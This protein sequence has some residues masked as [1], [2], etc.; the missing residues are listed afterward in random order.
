MALHRARKQWSLTE[1]ETITSFECW[2]QI[3]LY[4]LKSD[5]LFKDFLKP[6][7]TWQKKTK[8]NANR[9][10][11]DTAGGLT[12]AEKAENLELMLEQLANY[13]TIISRK[14]I[15]DNSTSMGQIWQAIRV[16]FGFQASGAHFLD[17]S[18]IIL[19]P[20]E[21]P[22]TLYQRLLAFVED[23]LLKKDGDI[24]HEGEAVKEDEELTPSL[25]NYVVLH[26]L[27]LVHPELP[28]SEDKICH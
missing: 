19:E 20:N 28:S 21:K 26:W 16:H 27:K 2:R 13:C 5:K 22:E 6:D 8:A 11:T 18:T 3:Q 14:T 23:N 25:H 7:V 10:F 15:V 24:T 12:A 4:C 9:G 17:F 1:D